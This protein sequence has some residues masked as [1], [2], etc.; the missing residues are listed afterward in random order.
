[1]S[2]YLVVSDIHRNESK[3]ES[4]LKDHQDITCVIFCGDLEM[5]VYDFEEIVRRCLSCSVDIRMVRGNCDA[6]HTSF[7]GVLDVIAFPLS[8]KHRVMVTHGHIY[9]ANYDLMAYAAME[10]E[11]DTVLFGHIHR[12]VDKM[13]SGI[14]FL[15]PGALMN[16]DYMIIETDKDGELHI[17]SERR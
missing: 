15:N 10:K 8:S 3:L 7:S 2:K 4:I 13:Y 14:R 12:H 9:R 17:S 16:G 11:C 6:Y 5:E 1:M